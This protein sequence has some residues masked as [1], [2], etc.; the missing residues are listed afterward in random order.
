MDFDA[1]LFIKSGKYSSRL[2]INYRS[3]ISHPAKTTSLPVSSVVIEPQLCVLEGYGPIGLHYD[4]IR[5]EF[6][7]LNL[8]DTD[9]NMVKQRHQR[10]I[11]RINGCHIA[12][13]NNLGL[14]EDGIRS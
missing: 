4:D 9:L 10:K 3:G 1:L 5:L 2:H 13:K 6:A 7:G 11:L 14:N 12:S 8:L